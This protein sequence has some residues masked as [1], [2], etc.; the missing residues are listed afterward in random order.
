MTSQS[1]TS[2]I[3]ISYAVMFFLM[4]V[5]L[6]FTNLYGLPILGL[7]GLEK[8]LEKEQVYKLENFTELN[9][10]LIKQWVTERRG[11]LSVIANDP[12]VKRYAVLARQHLQQEI[13][14]HIHSDHDE[15]LHQDIGHQDIHVRLEQFVENY[16]GIDS[17]YLIDTTSGKMIIHSETEHD[18][19]F[20]AKPEQIK[21][22]MT[23][24][25]IESVIVM[26]SPITGQLNLVFLHQL[27]SPNGENTYDNK[28]VTALVAMFVSPDKFL[29]EH[30]STERL[31]KLGKQAEVLLIDSDKRLLSFANGS[32]TQKKIQM[33][34]LRASI[35]SQLVN[36]VMTF[37]DGIF[38]TYDRNDEQV[39]AS[40]K[41]I[42]VTKN[43][44]WFMIVKQ[45]YKEVL[46]V[47][48]AQEYQY[49]IIGTGGL[50]MVI[51]LSLILS[52]Y[53]TRPLTNLGEVAG[54]IASGNFCARVQ[55]KHRDEIGRLGQS[56]NLMA[57]Q[58][59]NSQAIL[60]KQVLERTKQLSQQTQLYVALSQTNQMIVQ[61]KDRSTL[62]NRACQIAV[63]YGQFK[64]AWIG[65][66]D[67]ENDIECVAS[68]GDEGEYLCK[69]PVKLSDKERP[70]QQALNTQAM[71]RIDDIENE[72]SNFWTRSALSCGYHSVAVFPLKQQGVVIGVI[73]L[74]SAD[75][76]VFNNKQC[77]LIK[78]MAGDISFAMDSIQSEANR[79]LAE[80][81]I[82]IRERQLR[83]VLEGTA[84]VSGDVFFH[85]L[86]QHLS[87]ALSMKY[88]FIGNI[89][90]DNNT[91]ETIAVWAD[92]HAVDN[93]S[94]YLRAT[95]CQQVV[96]KNI[97]VFKRG[98]S[99]LF[100]DDQLLIEMGVESYAGVALHSDKNKP[101]GILVV[102]DDKEIEYEKDVMSMLQIFSRR[103]QLEMLRSRSEKKLKLAASVFDNASEGI[104]ITDSKT[105]IIT[106]NPAIFEITGYSI[107]ELIGQ[108][109]DV[110]R[111]GRHNKVFYQNMWEELST[112]GKWQG[113]I[114]NR[115][116]NGD[117]YLI[118]LNII[119]IKN[120]DGN[121]SHYLATFLDVTDKKKAQEHIKYIVHHDSLTGLPNR[122]LLY[123]RLNQAMALAKR[124]NHY[125]GVLFLDLDRFKNINDSL[126][127]EL[128]DLLLTMVAER[129]N[130]NIRN[131]ETIARLGGDDFVIVLS[132]IKEPEQQVVQVALKLMDSISKPYLLGSQELHITPS[133]GISIYPD[134]GEEPSTLLKNADTALYAAKD[135]GRNNYQFYTKAMNVSAFEHL[136][137]ENS[138]RRALEKNEFQLYYQPQINLKTEQIVGLEALIRWQ[139]PELGMVAP[140]QFISIA[141]E[142]GLIGAIGDW[143]LNEA[144]RQTKKWHEAG[145]EDIRIAVN[146]SGRQFSHGDL[147]SKVQSV[148]NETQ[149]APE[150]LELEIT[151]SILMD[152]GEENISLLHRLNQLGVELAIDDFGT[153]YS[154]LS[155][156]KAF[157][158]QRLK[159]DQSFVK[160][161]LDD[162]DDA[163]IVMAVIALAHSLK[164]SVIAEGAETIGQIEFLKTYH[165]DEVQGYYYSRPVPAS[166]IDELLLLNRLN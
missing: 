10:A 63:E 55:I 56:F 20:M 131:S 1:M 6:L 13:K 119:T 40:L 97:C 120:S 116:K 73:A 79:T 33:V 62:F 110:F 99:S 74:Y 152:R 81:Q 12:G 53:I 42:P 64:M 125:M 157:P 130:K 70:E 118:W 139:H 86:V 23:E 115:R 39:L 58:I 24:N 17:I 113:E 150:K 123:D 35:K 47:I 36:K 46:E 111:S 122:T 117:I 138:L 18:S 4:L 158:I 134:D 95:P 121:V 126:G 44:S 89:L 87:N 14:G 21:K 49:L 144:C 38:N 41:K 103:A 135:A 106:G 15:L 159:I 124:N 69:C 147:Y 90:D 164:L 66:V 128:G 137:M 9:V 85:S 25:A 51:L 146:I 71:V 102:L 80:Q 61:V 114:W 82:E 78:E 45:P 43:Y 3:V 22:A 72:P 67:Q 127:H 54:K 109:P 96:R 91:V 140:A 16:P 155:Y 27:F 161:L 143:V 156:L 84:G 29:Q 93:F 5:F 68:Y 112:Q 34:P 11:G 165:C 166:A 153:G 98:V 107:D 65:I 2:R 108:K 52:R 100:P 32:A 148:L 31:R 7:E 92:G 94:Y 8:H 145:Y 105:H 136:E 154:S 149:L 133:I 83:A 162:P 28:D 104:F 50:L 59:Q 37:K 30:L 75:V 160:E 19:K 141:E 163:S 132:G 57:N 48:H 142:S 129:L 88:A 151:E 26:K 60:E 76:R 77:E 101:I